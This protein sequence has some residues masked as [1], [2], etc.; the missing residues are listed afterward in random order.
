M[1]STTHIIVFA[2][3]LFAFMAS[4]HA[5]SQREQLN[6]M[7]E[8][9]QKTPSDNT[10]REKI[11]KLAQDMKPAPAI[12]EEANRAFV[13]GNVFQKEAKD[14]SGFELA[15]SAYRDALR[16]APWWSDAYYNLAVALESARKFDQAIAATRLYMA[17]LPAGGAEARE[18]QNRI[19]ALEAKGEI[20]VKEAV[21]A[22]P[23]VEG[24][25]GDGTMSFQVV[26]TGEQFA[27]TSLKVYMWPGYPMDVAID[28]THV[29]FTY[30][31][32]GCTERPEC[33]STQNLT[34]SASGNELTGNSGGFDIT[35]KRKP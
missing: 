26:R 3:A 24:K 10:L 29:R 18:A 5:Q 8:Q 31:H 9:L 13:K 35:L 15:I 16:V 11:I 32:G 7:V 34:L 19:Y 25:W 20:A 27:L 30:T 1:K 4:A 14:A 17:S 2:I 28:P 6:Q 12:P 22:K 21:A 23:T 33:V